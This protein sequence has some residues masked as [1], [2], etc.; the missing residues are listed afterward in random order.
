[1]DFPPIWMEEMAE[2]AACV[3]EVMVVFSVASSRGGCACSD[4][5]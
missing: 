4:C 5:G 3:M 1:M 2:S